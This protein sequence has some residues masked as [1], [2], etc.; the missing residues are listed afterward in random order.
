[1][2]NK[3]FLQPRDS[4]R[5]KSAPASASAYEDQRYTEQMARGIYRLRF[6]PELEAEFRAQSQGLWVR[7]GFA[8]ALLGLSVYLGF[9]PS[10]ALALAVVL[11][12][13]ALYLT[14]LQSRRHFLLRG[15]LRQQAQVD[16]LTGALNRRAFHQHLDLI[17][18]QAERDGSLIGLMLVDLDHFKQLNDRHGHPA[19]DTVLRGTTQILKSYAL[20]PLDAVGRYGGDEFIVAWHDAEP[21]AFAAV[22]Q[23]LPSKLWMG[24]AGIGLRGDITVSGGAVLARPGGGVSIDSAIRA[25]DEELYRVKRRCRGTIGRVAGI[26]GGEQAASVT[27]RA[28]S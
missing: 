9:A 14:S 25:A 21:K 27:T 10:A 2:R 26:L 6:A 5:A 18:R 4:D 7:R 24:L 12:W 16:G 3:R 13:L 15:E 23:L 8:A 28:S 20:R 17:W 11:G 22:V 19:G 1:M